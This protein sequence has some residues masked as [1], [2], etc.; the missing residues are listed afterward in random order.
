MILKKQIPEDFYKLFRTRNM[1]AYMMFLVAIY[2][3]N[4]EL[5][6]ALGLTLEEG[7]AIIAE[8][9]PASSSSFGMPTM[10]WRR[11]KM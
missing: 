9:M 2:E 11:R 8:T 7:Q 3:E 6:T 1:D 4:S 10:N 5:Y